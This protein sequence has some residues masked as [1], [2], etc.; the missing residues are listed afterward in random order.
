MRLPAVEKNEDPLIAM[1]EKDSHGDSLP[2]FSLYETRSKFYLIGRDTKKRTEWR[3]LKISR[4]EPCELNILE[5]ASSYTESECQDFL[6]RINE[7]N[8]STGGLKFVT[9]CY[10]IVGFIKFFGPY[11]ML[12]ITKR[13]QIGAICGHTVYAI[14]KSEIFSLGN[15]SLS[16]DV[17]RCRNESRYKKLFCAV[18]LS[19]DFFFS[20]SYPI[21][22]C[23]QKNFCDAHHGKPVYSS[24]FVWNEFLVRGM[25]RHLKNSFWTVALVYGFFQQSKLSVS[26]KDFK[27]TL[28]ARRSR[29]YAGTRYLKRGIND[30]GNVANDV[31]TEQI[32][33]ADSCHL[34]GPV[35]MSSIVQNRGSIPLFWSQETSRLNLKPDII[36]HKRDQKYEATRRHFMNLAHRYGNPIIILNLI[37]T[38]EKRPRESVL[39]TEF[40]RAIDIINEDL[41]VENRLK[42]LHWDLHSHFRKKTIN[43]LGFLGQVADRALQSTGFFCCQ[44]NPSSITGNTTTWPVLEGDDDFSQSNSEENENH[45]SPAEESSAPLVKFQN[46][47]LRTNCIDCLDRTNVAQYMYGLAALR[48]QLH[49]LGLIDVPEIPLDTPLADAL[50]SLYETMG[51]TLALQYGGSAAHNKIFSQ[52]RGHWKVTIQS[53]ELLRTLQRYYSNAYVD[54]EKQDA[55]NVFL[56]HLRPQQGR[57]FLWDIDPD[58]QLDLGRCGHVLSDEKLRSIFERSLSDGSIN[59]EGCSTESSTA[60]GGNKTLTVSAL[61]SGISDVSAKRLSASVPVIPVE[62]DATDCRYTPS[63]ICRS[64]VNGVEHRVDPT[65]WSNFM[66]LDWVSPFEIPSEENSQRSWVAGGHLS[67]DFSQP[68]TPRTVLMEPVDVASPGGGD[69]K[70]YKHQEFTDSF[71]HWVAFGETFFR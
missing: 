70:M 48:C 35:K 44:A 42:F 26:G 6:N 7:G 33:S 40:V 10:G 57:S 71:A 4:T 22:H 62:A 36:L 5:D 51:D 46:G 28:I 29:H 15:S 37:K 50:M 58:L 39:R 30:G 56:G 63:A 67:G 45:C 13:K 24:M 54:A 65:T 17:D 69:A 2:E 23:L 11:Y 49:E 60:I 34:E 61:T 55:I 16:L 64:K 20:Y 31:E 66:D 3:V 68:T 41:P 14:A 43:V 32:V 59:C 8:K 19:K 25:S 1:A 18:D 9:D 27:L 53:Q 47:V 52:W 38:I 21:M 12:L